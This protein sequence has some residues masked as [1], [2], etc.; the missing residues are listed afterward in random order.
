M[1]DQYVSCKREVNIKRKF[2]KMYILSL[3]ISLSGHAFIAILMHSN[4]NV[5]KDEGGEDA[6][7]FLKKGQ[8]ILLA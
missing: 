7:P 1:A 2:R 5:A 4:N 6:F 3:L 8:I